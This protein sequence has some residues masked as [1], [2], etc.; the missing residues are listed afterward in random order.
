MTTCQHTW[1]A[2]CTP[3]PVP[4]GSIPD[5]SSLDPISGF[6]RAFGPALCSC[7]QPLWLQQWGLSLRRDS[8]FSPAKREQRP[9]G[10]D[11]ELVTLG[12][13]FRNLQG[14]GARRWEAPALE[15]SL[16]VITAAKLKFLD[17]WNTQR[18]N[19]KRSDA[20]PEMRAAMFYQIFTQ[21]LKTT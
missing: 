10:A 4:T 1:G 7:V 21:A 20:Q 16:L 18:F 19:L 9:Y 12:K 5:P 17:L 8:A 15:M 11:G 6:G 2:V 13:S 14:T 3:I